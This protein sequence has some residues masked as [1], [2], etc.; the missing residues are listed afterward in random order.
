MANDSKKQQKAITPKPES[1][2][3]SPRAPLDLS[4]FSEDDFRGNV[5]FASLSVEQKL[6]WLS[7][8]ARFYYS[9]NKDKLF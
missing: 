6:R 2:N 7:N 5:D 3:S 8:A 9:F 4:A 1:E